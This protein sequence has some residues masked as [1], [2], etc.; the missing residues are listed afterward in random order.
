[1]DTLFDP[2]SIN[3]VTINNRLMMGPMGLFYTSD[4][5]INSRIISF[6]KERAKGGVGLID[7]G[8]CRIH[9]LAGGPNFIGLD[10]D[11]YI[12]GLQE[13][14]SEVHAFGTKI[15]AQL[16]HPGSAIH[17][18][19]LPGK[20]TVSSSDVRSDFSG[21]VPRALL[22]DEIVWVQGHFVDAALRAK[23]AG[24]DGVDIL[25]AAGYLISQFLS[26]VRNRRED[27]YGGSIENRMR[28]ALEI[29]DQM[30]RGLGKD[31]P[32]FFKMAANEFMPGG[33]GL[34][35]GRIF[36]AELERAGVD[37][38][39]T[40]GGWHETRVPQIVGSIPAGTWLYLAKSIKEAVRIPV[41][42][43][44]QIRDP[45]MA[46]KAIQDGIADMVGMARPFLA[47][48]HFPN[49]AK[50]GR[51]D[52]INHCIGCLQGC[53]DRPQEGKPVGC[54]VNPLTGRED[55]IRIAPAK[56]SKNVIVVGGGPGGLE[57]A[58]ILAQRGHRVT[59]HEEAERLGGQL[60]L[61][62]VPPGRGAFG[63]FTEYM[64]QQMDLQGVAL[65]LNSPITAEKILEEKPD[66]VVLATGARPL[67]P[68][69]PGMHLPHVCN[70]W[71]VLR[72]AVNV[73]KNVL[74][75]GGGATGCETALFLAQKGALGAESLA[76]L[77]LHD[78][79]ELQVLKNLL[80]KGVK[81]VSIVEKL[82]RVGMEIGPST[83][84][85]VIQNLKRFGITLLTETEVKAIEP[86]GVMVSQK[87]SEECLACDSVVTA[88]GARP[89][90]PLE[91][92]IE[93]KIKE[94]HVIGDAKKARKAI[95][96]VY[97]GFET[98]LKI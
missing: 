81:N 57:A 62:A 94:V 50:E 47:D 20:E 34:K 7:V 56:T 30:R 58:S 60:S 64:K 93:D 78:A 63:L 82:P 40:A 66:A 98:G 76:W 10:D 5:H 89:H 17:A 22:P 13:L 73:G 96:A 25:G 65:I 75:L 35:E 80:N 86:E 90:N 43:C 95:D 9:E 77:F 12:P 79:E 54:M 45:R 69:I 16:Y 28:F 23:K 11:I 87:G 36:A 51:F 1:M 67:I 48:P 3:G 74:I 97:E 39:I 42:T 21:Q 24:F 55:E 59:L 61:A 41:I 68:D 85:T 33:N 2:I 49:K 26:P 52:H 32:I 6:F 72:G 15:M 14:T 18:F 31:F 27:R 4:G 70:A 53:F 19:L 84:W 46:D 71:D 37:C 83:R 91:G 8:A 88:F 92:R 29:V 44:N 38:I